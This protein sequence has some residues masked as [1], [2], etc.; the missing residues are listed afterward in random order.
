MKRLTYIL[1]LLA[2]TLFVS[3]Q[4]WTTH[5]AYNSVDRIAAGGG[6]VYCVS[7]G[8]LFAVDAQ[9]EKITTYST[10][11]GMHGTNIAC[12]Q[13]LEP[14][15]ALMIVYQDGKVDMLTDGIFRYIPDL[16]SKNTTL[17]KRCHSVTLNDSLAY[18]AMDYGVQT[19]H[20][21]KQTFVD[22][23][24]IGPE[25][26]EVP[27]YSIA[28]TGQTI[29]A[30]G[31]S[32]LYAA[33]LDDNIVDYSYWAEIPLP[34]NGKIQGIAQANGVLYLLLDNTCY[35]RQGTVWQRTSPTSYNVLNVLDG[36]V[37]PGTYPTVSYSG[38]WMAAG[39]QGLIRQMTT[40]EEVTYRLD[41]PLNNT[42]YRLSYQHGRL[43]MVSGGRWAEQYKNPACVMLY[44]GKW[45]NLSQSDIFRSIGADCLDVMNVAV[46]HN[47]HSHYFATTY[48]T[49]LLEFRDETC[50]KQ[51]MPN[52]SILGSASS[53]NPSKYT[54]TDGAIFDNDG[55]L[56][57][58][59]CGSVPYNVVVFMKNGEQVG[60]NVNN[61]SGARATLSTASQIILDRNNPNYVWVL[62]SR[63]YESTGALAL[64]DTKGTLSDT[65]DDESIIRASWQDENGN[66]HSRP[67]IYCMRQDK[68]GNIWLA[69]DN[70]ILIIHTDDYFNASRCEH[71]QVSDAEGMVLFENEAVNDIC[72]DH[73]GRPWIATAGTG[74][75][76]L[77]AEADALAYHYTT[78]NSALP[79][80][81]ILSLAY[82]HRH[83]HMYIGTALGL[84]AYIDPSSDLNGAD[85]RESEDIDYGTMQ[86]WTTHFAYSDIQDIQLSAKR[87]FALSLGSLCSIDR[88]DDAIT[89]YSKLNGL[90]G[91]AI[92]RIDYDSH[93]GMLVISYEDGMIDLM[94]ANENI[95]SVADLYN[96]SLN[97]S[98]KVQDLAFS[99]GKAYM[100]MSFGIVVMNI[101]KQEI[102]DTYY[103]G[104]KGAEV[105]VNAITIIG[106]SIYAAV[107]SRLYYAH[108]NDNLVDFS[109]WHS[110]TLAY[111]ISALQNLNGELCM[112]ADSVI[113]HNR[114]PL[115]S[116]ERFIALYAHDGSILARTVN[117]AVYEVTADS[118][119]KAVHASAYEPR[120]VR[121]EGNTYWLGNESGVL[122][123]FPDNSVQKYE[124]DGPLSNMPY[125]LTASGSQLWMVTGGRWATQYSRSGQ[126]M[127]YDSHKWHNLT[128]WDIWHMLGYYHWM[129]DFGHVAV[130]PSDP[131]HYYVASFGTG[132]LEFSENT[133][134]RH[135]YSNSPLVSIDAKNPDHYCR[136]D[137]M[138]YDADGNLW[139]TNTGSLANNIHVIDPAHNWHSFNIYQGGQRIVLN[140]VSKFLVDNTNSKYK[141]IAS[142]R[143]NAGII[144]LNDNGTP[145]Y[146]ADDRSVIRSSFVDQDGKGV[147]M[148]A[149]YTIAQDFNGDMWLGTDEGIIVVEA[150]TDIF[151]SNT[152]HRLKMSRHDDTGLADY[153]LGTERINAIVFAGNNRIW[154]G[155]EASGVYLV[156][157]VTKEGIYEPEIISHFTSQNSPMPSDCVQSIAID[158]R[159]EV[160]IGTA[161]GLVSYRG[162]ATQPEETFENAYIYPNPVRP[163]FEGT[164]AITGL[165]EGTTVFI[166]DAAGNVVCR[167][168]SN[169]GTAIWDGKTQSGKKAH[170][171]VYTVYC[172]TADGKNHTTLKLLLMH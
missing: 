158:E 98:K 34:A 136:V 9:T 29:Y 31:D 167:T 168:H 104:D 22:T 6:K 146:S 122:H 80:N 55:N 99:Q 61:T 166:A 139:L 170:S 134:K 145:Y 153:L 42:P 165:M 54:R 53:S 18:M 156:H 49:G 25:A 97:T 11:D 124:P 149:L 44:D 164:I 159:G 102:K 86:Q 113:Y 132:L 64:I 94:D 58:V 92:N 68:D 72:F 89:Y 66:Q 91:S 147:N 125:S 65:S 84:V 52:N 2:L 20:I 105:S 40:G 138:T 63:A 157:M 171:G 107:G 35:R 140:T 19:F 14:V 172:N 133:V 121:K 169:G 1:T 46:D 78:G 3:A 115:A 111:P 79:S 142:A 117:S 30:A 109:K 154:I 26:K 114:T 12:I 67:A 62:A 32:I 16:Y 51:W 41:G 128:H 161:S 131:N 10:Q 8:A 33:S 148:N 120:C 50:I 7:S 28:L 56:W 127:R 83:R 85:N 13:W 59:N 37:I 96:K 27:V 106:D 43:Y 69:T 155:T 126:V 87:I 15:Q 71:L 21:R 108:L 88:S 23:Y 144:V 93:T 116:D 76:V 110:K 118:L 60:M 100:A 123:M 36:K 47:D 95:H 90:N 103:I 137:A 39:E 162:D 129:H 150:G 112:L 143:A 48:G 45:H 74:V 4:T 119:S 38:S 24:F 130:D 70:G 163:N 151:T 101:R 77:D 152:C 135:T 57:L 73:L 75:Y 82:D 141:W 160:Y 17:S 81:S 5:F